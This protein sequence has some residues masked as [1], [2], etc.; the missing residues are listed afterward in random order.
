MSLGQPKD[1][2]YATPLEKI[3]DFKF[4]EKVASVFPDMIRRSVPGYATII[5][6][7]GVMAERFFVPGSTCYDLG[8]SLGA[9][10]LVMRQRLSGKPGRIIAVDNSEAMIARARELLVNEADCLPVELRCADLRAVPIENA[11]VVVLNFTLQFIPAADRARVIQTI[12]DGLRPGGI[13]ILSEKIAFDD[14]HKAELFSDLHHAFKKANGYSD[15]EVAQKRAA[16]ENVLIPETVVQHRDRLRSC[17]F[18]NVDV[19]FQCFNFASILA[20]K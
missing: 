2:I 7:I 8:C 5:T 14:P 15:L 1:G 11:S 13:L 10:T 12:Y 6:T 20:V 3:V 17:G 9:A 18:S 4:D 19:W 16:L